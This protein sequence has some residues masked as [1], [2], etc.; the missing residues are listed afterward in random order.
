MLHSMLFAAVFAFGNSSR[1]QTK[2]LMIVSLFDEWQQGETIGPVHDLSAG[3]TRK[4]PAA[5]AAPPAQDRP[6]E[7]VS[8]AK[9]QNVA[10]TVPAGGTAAPVVQAPA[11]LPE[12]G[13]EP[14]GMN[15]GLA[16]RFQDDASGG[17]LG[18]APAGSAA[19]SLGK[20]GPETGGP[21]TRSDGKER[22]AVD[23]DPA[24]R[25]KIRDTLQANLVYPY[26]ARKKRIE[27]TVFAEFQLNNSGMPENMRIVRTS[28]YAILDEAAKE[29][30][31]KA[32]PYPAQNRR[33]EIP[34]TFRLRD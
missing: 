11:A 9:A 27:G 3:S 28:N 5:P 18:A 13:V 19:M 15:G 14:V 4:T 6:W 8:P 17:S 2:Q 21:G 26:L 29:T 1:Q 31:Q 16:G 24:L 20:Y 23:S 30:I 32:A 22:Q 7:R 33:V 34:I 12:K 10:A 25:K